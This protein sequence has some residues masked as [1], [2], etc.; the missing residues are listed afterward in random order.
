MYDRIFHKVTH[1]G[2]GSEKNY[3]NRFL[4]AQAFSVSAGKTY[5]K[6]QWMKIFLDNFHQ[7]G[8]YTAHIDRNQSELRRE[9]IFTDHKYLSITS[10]QTDYLN[11]ES[12]SVSGRKHERENLVH[13]TS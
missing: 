13:N 8:K 2:G 4:N 9:V 12:S 6:Y 11:I 3:I 7:G 1:K 10:L 5:Y